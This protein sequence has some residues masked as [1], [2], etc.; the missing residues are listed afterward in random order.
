MRRKVL[1][2]LFLLPMIAYGQLD[3]ANARIEVTELAPGLHRF[4]VERVAVLVFHGD[5]GV[6]LVDAAYEP[7]SKRLE[8]EVEKI[9]HTPLR[10]IINTHIHG[11]HTGGNIGLGQGVDI[12]A[13][14]SV[15]EYL[16][17]DQLRGDRLVPALPEYARPN[18]TFTDH[19]TLEF[20]GEEIRM[21]HLYGGHTEGDILV[22]F[23]QSRV[24]SVGD[25]VFAGYF[26]FVDTG[27]GGHPFRFMDNLAWIV[28]NF[29]PDI[30]F[31]GGHGPALNH[32]EMI[33]YHAT[34]QLTIDVIQDAKKAGMSMD[35]MKQNKI[36]SRWEDMGSF[37]ITEDRWIETVYPFL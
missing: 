22:Y 30:T 26:P 28:N 27:N 15:K 16:S 7:S 14:H 23:P 24:L 33:Q 10:Y 5:E 13:H 12:I 1:L 29:D 21:Y 11:D 37:F 25:L 32:E 9:T 20:N 31:V 34:L 35:E 17:H 19:M 8:E 36:L 2:A 4:Y 18:I 3:L 6:L